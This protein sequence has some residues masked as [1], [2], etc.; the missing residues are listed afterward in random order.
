MCCKSCYISFIIEQ[1]LFEP[2]E[3]VE[4]SLMTASSVTRSR[5]YHHWRAWGGDSVGRWFFESIISSLALDTL[6][7]IQRDSKNIDKF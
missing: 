3:N 5:G 2:N 1:V 6:F 7:K 4:S